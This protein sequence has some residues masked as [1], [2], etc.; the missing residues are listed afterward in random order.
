MD[1]FQQAGYNAIELKQLNNCYMN[2]KVTTLTEIMD[3]TGQ[4]IFPQA[5]LQRQILPDLKSLSHSVYT[6]LDQPQPQWAA[7]A[8]QTK[9]ISN[10]TWITNNAT[11]HARWMEP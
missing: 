5:T 11:Y 8:F 7:W 1:D 3:H 6:W 10:Q 2:L 9:V 4:F